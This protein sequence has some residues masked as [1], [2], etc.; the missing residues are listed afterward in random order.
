MYCMF[1]SA[2]SFSWGDAAIYWEI[3]VLQRG[4]NATIRPA[5]SARNIKDAVLLFFYYLFEVRCVC[6][7]VLIFAI[8]HIQT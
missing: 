6:S 2:H 8:Q 5:P 3:N 4:A 1:V 7:A